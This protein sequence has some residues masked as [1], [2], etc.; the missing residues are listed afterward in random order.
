[1]NWKKY[2]VLAIVVNTLL[3]VFAACFC[4]H[5]LCEAQ[6]GEANDSRIAA[7]IAAGGKF[8]PVMEITLPAADDTGCAKILDLESGRA[9][10][11]PPAEHFNYNASTIVAWLRSNGLDIS[12]FVWPG[13]A[14]CVT[15]EMNIVAV[16]C[17]C[18]EKTTE[19]ELLANPVLARRSHSPRKLLVL[20][21]NR[22]D[23][24]L[25]RTGEGTL[26]MLRILGLSQ[27][28]RGVKVSYK[29]ITP[30]KSVSVAL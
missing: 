30:V 10:L 27:D 16:D 6:A 19:K 13:G 20:G 28:R 7:V 18:W 29:L 12:C 25:F 26:G 1:M 21:E 9:L 5:F 17:K 2:F 3:L 11:Q 8:G 23:T 4:R 22:P 15:Y 14:T 24:Y